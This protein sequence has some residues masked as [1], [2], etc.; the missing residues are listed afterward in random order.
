MQIE[1]WE[2]E[3]KTPKFLTV[4]DK[5]QEDILRFIRFLK[6]KK[7]GFSGTLLDLGCGAGK[8][9]NFFAGLGFSVWGFDISNT[10]LSLAKERAKIDN[11]NVQYDFKNIGEEFDFK[12]ESFDI[13]LDVTS[14]N[15]LNEKE[16]SLYIKEVYRLLKK[17]GYFFFKGLCLESDQNAKNLI[18]NFAG[19]EKD[20]YFLKD[21]GLVER[22]WSRKDLEDF[23]GEFFNFQF[24]D[25]KTSYLQMSGRKYKRNFWIAYLTK[26]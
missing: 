9:S 6:K 3:Y 14:S 2:R 15:S 13:I 17:D 8:N 16:R 21:I 18:K 25:K 22:V 20:T 26:K 10:A 23:Y 1:A 7:T 4:S 11:L 12:D 19:K 24:L 5:P